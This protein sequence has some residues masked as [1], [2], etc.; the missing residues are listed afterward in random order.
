MKKPTLAS[1]GF[2]LSL[3]PLHCRVVLLYRKQFPCS[4][5]PWGLMSSRT[6]PVPLPDAWSPMSFRKPRCRFRRLGP[7]MVSEGKS[8][9]NLMPYFQSLIYNDYRREMLKTRKC[10]VHPYESLLL[11]ST[12]S[13]E[14]GYAT[15]VLYR[16]AFYIKLKTHKFCDFIL[17]HYVFCACFMRYLICSIF[18]WQRWVNDMNNR[19]IFVPYFK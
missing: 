9:V 5:Y 18:S 2:S 10:S 17:K 12:L 1:P 15:I 13:H 8:L 6:P 11:I 4:F 19:T 14:A 3:S 16:V 7:D